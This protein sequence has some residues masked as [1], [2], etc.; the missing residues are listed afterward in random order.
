MIILDEPTASLDQINKTMVFELLRKLSEQG[1]YVVFTSHEEQAKSYA[2]VIYRIEDRKLII[3]KNDVHVRTLPKEPRQFRQMNMLKKHI[4]CFSRLNIGQMILNTSFIILIT[5][6]CGLAGVFTSVLLNASRQELYES[7]DKYLYITDASNQGFLDIDMP[8]DHLPE[9][10]LVYKVRM[11]EDDV[12]VIPY[13]DEMNF[14]GKVA[15]RYSY[16]KSGMYVSHGAWE[17][18]KNRVQFRS[19]M[20][21]Q[22]IIPEKGIV[23]WNG[24]YLGILKQG[25]RSYILES[26]EIYLSIY[27][28]ELEDLCTNLRPCGIILFYTDIENLEIDRQKYEDLGYTVNADSARYDNILAVS[29]T[30]EEG[31]IRIRSAL[32][33][34]G[35][36]MLGIADFVNLQRRSYELALLKSQGISPANIALMLSMENLPAIV[37]SAL[38]T[39][40]SAAVLAM[41]GLSA[42]LQP[43]ILSLTG[44]LLMLAGLQII[45]TIA[46]RVMNSE[47]IF[48][49]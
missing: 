5:L 23:S 45:N 38:I 20:D 37:I 32:F 16:E 3:E 1:H 44:V 7:T 48:R 43:L 6:L 35:A 49:D 10:Y 17:I 47:R 34:L 19:N 30:Q 26:N 39:V 13:Y 15:T 2:D 12:Y 4:H 42:Y 8:C 27:F 22:L 33:L 18:M 28:K 14:D 21:L 11:L 31:F 25:V 41:A 40:F 9:G 46:L 24:N 29:L 36:L